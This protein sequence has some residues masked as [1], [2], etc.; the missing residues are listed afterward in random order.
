M[1]DSSLTASKIHTMAVGISLDQYLLTG[2][3][4]QQL[5]HYNHFDMLE[6]SEHS[7]VIGKE[8][9]LCD[10]E[11]LHRHDFFEIMLVVNGDM[12][13]H[14]ENELLELH[15]GDLYLLNRNVRHYE[16]F[17]GTFQAAYFSISASFAELLPTSFQ[18]TFHAP[19]K[20]LR[21]FRKNLSDDVQK[22][23]EYLLFRSMDL[24]PPPT[25][26]YQIWEN[27]RQE[28][29]LKEPGYELFLLGWFSRLFSA[30]ED[31]ASYHI[32]QHNLGTVSQKDLSNE[33]MD[34]IHTVKRKVTRAEIAKN[35]SYNSDY[36]N[37]IFLQQTN[38]SITDYSQKVCMIEAA[39]LL[40]STSMSI[41]NIITRLGYQN[42][43]HFNRLFRETYGE[44]PLEY[45]NTHTQHVNFPTR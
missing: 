41:S 20:I 31:P 32:T 14:I 22:N 10:M 27:I 24:L 11:V 15:P 18:G 37:R 38:C 28:L 7:F 2:Q 17:R 4:G 13:V 35:L 34:Y 26:P 29:L 30:M 43:T 45:R 42:R 12:T 6:H 5:C 39:R 3:N 8:I 40:T 25:R 19:V 36:L 44:T 21:F 1:A 9:S 23:K 33:I 16:E